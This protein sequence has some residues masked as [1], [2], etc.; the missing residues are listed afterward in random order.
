MG[1]KRI[2]VFSLI[3]I[4][5]FSGGVF[6]KGEP[7]KKIKKLCPD[8]YYSK[9]KKEEKE[10]KELDF[11]LVVKGKVVNKENSKV[12]P[13][14]E[15]DR[16]YVPLRY[17]SEAFD[18]QV[19]WMDEQR[20]ITIKKGSSTIK[21]TPDSLE[22][23]INGKKHSLD[24]KPVI[25]EGR[26]FVPIRFVAESL[27]LS[28]T[29]D[30]GKRVASIKKL[31]KELHK[32]RSIIMNKVVKEFDPTNTLRKEIFTIGEKGT[33]TVLHKLSNGEI[34]LIATFTFNNDYL[35]EYRYK[36]YKDDFYKLEA[37][38][39]TRKEGKALAEEFLQEVYSRKDTMIFTENPENI[40]SSLNNPEVW[41]V[42]TTEDKKISIVVDRPIG[43]I[44][45]V[46]VSD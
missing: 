16:I 20:E 29:W 25:R 18:A 28:V 35:V 32:D 10:V 8:A 34:G 6:G 44:L 46:K 15:S 7:S 33:Y 22:F 26:T 40:P 24:V 45:F 21:M 17:I 38:N 23:M 43:R 14:I 30:E 2:G 41:D 1:M 3:G 42:F 27:G 5:F 31:D 37:K 39:L 12:E 36:S 4:L 13:F 19:E 11:T 9:T